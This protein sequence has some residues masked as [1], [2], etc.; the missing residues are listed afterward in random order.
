[1]RSIITWLVVLTVIVVPL[2]FAATSSLLQWREP[3]YI[4]AGL[5]GVIALVFLFCQPL[6]AAGLLPGISLLDSRRIHRWLGFALLLGVIVHVLGLWV[7]SPPDV[8]DA[9]LFQSPTPFSAWGVIA[10]WLVFAT[11]CFAVFRSKLRLSAKLWR[12]SHKTIGLA[13]VICSVVH[14]L[15]IDGT[16][17][18]VSKLVLC[19][20]LV[21]ATTAAIFKQR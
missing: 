2:G 11:A 7:T 13:I 5:A 4:A 18:F 3:F 15:L 20:F 6:L 8:I 16:M 14:A 17:E 10:M 19:G 21:L 12:R 9:L 1:M